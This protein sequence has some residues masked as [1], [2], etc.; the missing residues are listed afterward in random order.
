MSSASEIG[1]RLTGVRRYERGDRDAVQRIAGDTA[2]F[3]QPIEAHMEDRRPF[4]DVF[5]AYYTDHEAD[6]CWVAEAHGQVVGYLTGCPDSARQARVVRK[7]M[8]PAVLRRLLCGRYRIGR[9]T[10]RYILRLALGLLRGEFPQ[11]DH[12]VYPAH[13]HVNV[14]EGWRGR[15]LGRELLNG[16]L[17]QLRAAGVV[18]VHLGTT[19]YNRAAVRLYRSLGFELLAAR[20][21]RMWDGIIAEP[22]DN[23]LLGLRLGG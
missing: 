1:E 6:Y 23:L 15:G 9:K 7:Q 5:V 2:F 13:L 20:R 19:S 18:G 22:M 12:K 3:G 8:L 21:S 11:P 17:A 16:Y 14:A 10:Y 4:L